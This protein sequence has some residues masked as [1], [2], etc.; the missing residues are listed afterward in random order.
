MR[1]DPSRQRGARGQHFGACPMTSAIRGRSPSRSTRPATRSRGSRA[2]STERSARSAAGSGSRQRSSTRSRSASPILTRRTA[3]RRSM[4]P[5]RARIMR[6]ATLAALATIGASRSWAPAHLQRRREWS[7]PALRARRT[8]ARA[9]RRATTT[10]RSRTRAAATRSRSS[11]ASTTTTGRCIRCRWSCPRR[12]DART[13]RGRRDATGDQAD[14]R[15]CELQLRDSR[16]GRHASGS[17]GRSSRGG[18]R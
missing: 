1:D 18:G 4:T 11:P 5:G 15:L 7:H 10:G 13:R 14:G 9:R 16:F 6:R 17:R 2:T 3:R 8:R 12:R